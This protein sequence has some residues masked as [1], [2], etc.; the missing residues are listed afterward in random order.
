MKLPHDSLREA[1]LL[2]LTK[3]ISIRRAQGT[4]F[5]ALRRD[6][7]LSKRGLDLVRMRYLVSSKRIT[8]AG[9]RTRSN[10]RLF[11]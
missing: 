11:R 4:S 10:S 1:I 3:A 8:S 5:E 6:F 2:E 7:G 9:R